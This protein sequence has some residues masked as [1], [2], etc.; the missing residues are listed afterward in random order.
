MKSSRLSRSLVSAVLCIIFL[1]IPSVNV[2][3]LPRYAAMNYATGNGPI[4]TADP[5]AQA[6]TVNVHGARPEPEP[7]TYINDEYR[8][9][10]NY[11]Q[12]W[13]NQ[14]V[15]VS[16]GVF[17]ARGPYHGQTPD[18]VYIAIRPATNLED[19]VRAFVSDLIIALGYPAPPLTIESTDNI[20][21]P[22]GTEATMFVGSAKIM[23]IVPVKAAITCVMMTDGKAIMVLFGTWPGNIDL[24]I[25]QGKTLTFYSI[26][27]PVAVTDDATD[28]TDTAATLRGT[29]SDD[30]WEPC[31]HRFRYRTSTGVYTDNISWS[32]DNKTSVAAFSASIS[33]LSANTPYYYVAECK[34]DAGPAT[35]LEKSFTTTAPALAVTTDNAT[36]ITA[37]T[38]IINGSLINTGGLDTTVIICSGTSDGGMIFANWGRSDN[39]I[40]TAN[41]PFSLGV[42][43]LTPR[44]TYY[45]RC[46][47]ENSGSPA[48]WSSRSSSFT[49]QST[50]AAYWAGPGKD[51]FWFSSGTP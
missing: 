1:T 3:A 29:L 38:A 23:G 46:Y 31:Q 41:G 18:L 36:S 8:F 27:K 42:E 43:R 48:A 12:T 37:T 13:D 33:G 16:G 32:G 2:Y 10:V 22:D 35:G 25:K 20:T 44:T 19:A 5:L 15:T 14:T 40:T 51:W 28:I 34:N 39:L 11:P 4:I 26:L 30:G 6:Y 21:L 7:G 49:T 24:Y 9:S 45:Y 50:W 17:F 47:A